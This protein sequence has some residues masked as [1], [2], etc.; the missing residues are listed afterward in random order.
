MRSRFLSSKHSFI[1]CNSAV[2]WS[3]PFPIK[4]NNVTR[5]VVIIHNVQYRLFL[6]TSYCQFTIGS[7][8]YTVGKKINTL[9]QIKLDPTDLSYFKSKQRRQYL[10]A[11]RLRWPKYTLR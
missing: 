3:G 2:Q 10:N 9:L 7:V 1:N 4:I 5:Y 8:I 11:M 6:S